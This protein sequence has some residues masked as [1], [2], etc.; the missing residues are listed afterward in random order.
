MAGMFPTNKEI[1]AFGKTVKFPGVDEN[2]KFTNGDFSNPDIPPSFLDANT[3]NLIIDNLNALIAHLGGNANNTDGEQLKK[4]FSITAEAN[5]AIKR[6]SEGRA[7]VAPPVEADDI[8][9]K[10][11]VDDIINGEVELKKLTVQGDIVQRGENKITHAEHVHTK[12]DMIHLRE[13]AQTALGA[14]E[15][16]GLVAEKYDGTKNGVLGF[17]KDGIARVGDKGDEQPLACRAENSEMTGGAL[18]GWNALKQR[19]ESHLGFKFNG[20][21]NNADRTNYAVCSTPAATQ[22]K[23]CDCAGFNL[24][25]GA[26]ITVKFTMTNTAN[27]PMLN[28]NNTGAKPIYYRGSEVASS[29]LSANCTYTFRYNGS[30]Y[31]LVG[32]ISETVTKEK[33][34]LG[35]VDNTPDSKKNVNSAKTAGNADT[36]DGFHAGSANG[37]LV[38]IVESKF[39]ADKGYLKLMNGLILQWI[40]VAENWSEPTRVSFPIKFS[41]IPS[42][43]GS[44]SHTGADSYSGTVKVFNKNLEGFNISANHSGEIINSSLSFFCIGK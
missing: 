19:L 29:I 3:V 37:M 27:S 17:G 26:E 39:E 43:L 41:E 22:A 15:L 44:M 38:P 42:V 34:G 13:G 8:A 21:Q 1:T 30:Q 36:V 25:T 10:K 35:D 11:E 31:E 20:I 4:L 18:V 5:K 16:A 7:K 2:G 32:E 14:K 33:I 24:V 40:N 12:Q 6:D 28:V 23:N 9:R